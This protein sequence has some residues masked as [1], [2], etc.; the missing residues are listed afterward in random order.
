VR[1]GRTIVLYSEAEAYRRGGELVEHHIHVPEADT[2]ALEVAHF[3]ECV[4]T[5]QEP[6]TSGRAQR[7]PLEA[8][9]AAYRS[10][11][12]GGQTVPPSAL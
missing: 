8:V 6:L 7:W 12:S 10:M 1:G 9:L 4:R 2:F 5:G 11:E 3:M